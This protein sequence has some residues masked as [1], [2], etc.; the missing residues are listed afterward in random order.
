MTRI[1]CHEYCVSVE[2][3]PYYEIGRR[4]KM[5]RDYHGVTSEVWA[6]RHG[7]SKSQY[8]NWEAGIRRIP[9]EK[10]EELADRYGLTLE[11]IYRGRLAVGLSDTA[12]KIFSEARPIA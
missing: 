1:V 5:L 4:L 6:K 7:Y 11:L 3:N 9:V 12:M 8:T 10:A 2:S